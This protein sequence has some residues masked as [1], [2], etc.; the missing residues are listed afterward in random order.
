MKRTILLIMLCVNA[1]FG[2]AQDNHPVSW[3]FSSEKVGALTY[4]IKLVAIIRE[5]FHIYPGPSSD[6]GLGM[7]TEFLFVENPNVQFIGAM[8]EK[9]VEQKDSEPLPYYS[10][11]VTFTQT[12]R[13]KAE[14]KT[15]LAFTI[16]YIACTNEMCLPP[17]SREFTLTLDQKSKN[18]N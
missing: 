16:K 12:L 10:K 15:T 3:K 14:K 17:S 1:F 11:G 9:G 2:F 5:P 4:K 13:L 6:A 7:P 8:E 18:K